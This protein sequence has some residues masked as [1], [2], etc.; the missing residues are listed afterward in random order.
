VSD[1]LLFPKDLSHVVLDLHVLVVAASLEQRC[2]LEYLME[3]FLDLDEGVVGQVL[4][5]IVFH[6]FNPV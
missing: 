4:M 3:V 6:L 1:A 2:P 5:H